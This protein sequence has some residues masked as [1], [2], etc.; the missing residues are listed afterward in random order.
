MIAHEGYSL[1]FKRINDQHIAVQ[2]GRMEHKPWEVKSG[3][4]SIKTFNRAVHG[5]P[6]RIRND[7][8]LDPGYIK[9]WH[10]NYKEK[11]FIFTLDIEKKYH[12]GTN[13]KPIDFEFA[14]VK[15]FIAKE[16]PNFTRNGLDI[17][18]DL[19]GIQKL[20]PGM[21]FKSGM[22]EGVRIIDKDKVAVY[23]ND[24]NPNFIFSISET[25]PPIGPIESF[26]EDMYSFKK[27]PV[28]LGAFK[29][30]WSDPSSSLV[31]LERV[32]KNV[33]KDYPLLVDLY[34]EGLAYENKADIV[35][36]G[37]VQGMKSAIGYREFVGD[38][39]FA[40][41]VMDFNYRTTAGSNLLFRK[42]IALA[43]NRDEIFKAYRPYMKST[44]NLIPSKYIGR[45]LEIDPM[46]I[47]LAKDIFSKLPEGI[48]NKTHKMIYHGG[49]KKP[50][51]YILSI[52][53]NLEKIGM[54]TSWEMTNGVC[55]EDDNIVAFIYGRPSQYT[56]P[57]NLFTFYLPGDDCSFNAPEKDLKFEKLIKKASR[58]SDKIEKGR[59]LR[60]L[61]EHFDK[62]YRMIALVERLPI[63]YYSEKIKISDSDIG[64][65]LFLEDIQIV[66]EPTTTQTQ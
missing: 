57:V 5:L 65:G 54:K 62:E 34:N 64:F 21:K 66:N 19:K 47:E 30:S 58:T 1:P 17:L 22:L 52:K 8:S 25:L 46:N 55:L 10:W 40:I 36:G 41:Q 32:N 44:I 2:P 48:K 61:S 9:D 39:P 29:V 26:D 15:P 38:L 35:L 45:K 33:G 18:Y 63:V 56:D 42:A 7:L 37:A 59:F 60:E 23:L 4:S 14:I 12:D 20:K 16:G 50:H 49:G 3:G 11:K 31:R 27:L 53:S 6:I 43:L 51:P 13:L 28:G 24:E